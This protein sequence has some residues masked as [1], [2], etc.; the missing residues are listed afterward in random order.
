LIGTRRT[1]VSFIAPLTES[2][3]RIFTLRG[4]SEMM[5]TTINAPMTYS[6]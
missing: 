6:R 4:T 2:R 5:L 3:T 1:V